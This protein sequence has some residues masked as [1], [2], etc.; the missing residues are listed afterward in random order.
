MKTMP[1]QLQITVREMK[2]SEAL[3]ARVRQKVAALERVH[4][5]MTA[6]RVTAEAPHHH[7][8]HGNLY[9]VRLD[10]TVPGEEIV[11]NRDHAKDIYVALRDAFLAARRQL[12]EHAERGQRTDKTHRLHR[13]G[14]AAPEGQPDE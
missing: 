2:H 12:I 1:A 7:Q 10:I 11:I 3:E 9:N 13:R 4:P 8:R 6:C 14:A 5:R